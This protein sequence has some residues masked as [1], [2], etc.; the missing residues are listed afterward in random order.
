MTEQR[1]EDGGARGNR[2]RKVSEVSLWART[3]EKEEDTTEHLG[4]CTERRLGILGKI[5]KD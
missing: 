5:A 1:G 3:K 4:L 2:I